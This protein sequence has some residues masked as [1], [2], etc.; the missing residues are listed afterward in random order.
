MIDNENE[1]LESVDEF[2][3]WLGKASALREVFPEY[4]LRDSSDYLKACREIRDRLPT[5]IAISERINPAISKRITYCLD[6]ENDLEAVAIA[7]QRLYLVLE[8]E[9]HLEC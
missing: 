8:P 6:T 7:C 9:G 1:A 4:V 5:I 2:V 3:R